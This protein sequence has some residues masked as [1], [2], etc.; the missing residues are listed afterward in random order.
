MSETSGSDHKGRKHHTPAQNFII[1]TNTD[2]YETPLSLVRWILHLDYSY[3]TLNLY[4]ELTS[5][6]DL[7]C[8][9]SRQEQHPSF[10]YAED[11]I[12][13]NKSAKR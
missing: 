12:V 10:Q 13:C 8:Y 1:V 7:F 11:F 9:C 3:S 5:E 4:V 2:Y 6:T